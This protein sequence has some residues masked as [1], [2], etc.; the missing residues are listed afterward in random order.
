MNKQT[1]LKD[2]QSGQHV[3]H[4]TPNW[5]FLNLI[6]KPKVNAKQMPGKKQNKKLSITEYIILCFVCFTISTVKSCNIIYL[7]QYLF[8]IPNF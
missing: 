2:F 4:C 3:F 8:Q 6:L 7:S 5:L 1:P